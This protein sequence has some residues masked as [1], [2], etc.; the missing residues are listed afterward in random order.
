MLR[1]PILALT[2]DRTKTAEKNNVCGAP[3][4]WFDS[5][6]FRRYSIYSASFD[7]FVDWSTDSVCDEVWIKRISDRKVY[8]VSG[9]NRRTMEKW[10]RVRS[11]GGF[12]HVSAQPH[13]L[14]GCGWN[15]EED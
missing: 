10:G 8:A 2:S 5:E 6:Y 12:V 4:D 15:T 3:E 13:L 11:G 9:C 1:K 14:L 7:F